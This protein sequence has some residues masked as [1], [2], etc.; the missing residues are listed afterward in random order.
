MK[1]LLLIYAIAVYAQNTTVSKTFES[2][3]E[4]KSGQSQCHQLSRSWYKL[5]ESLTTCINDY[6]QN[7]N[8]WKT[9]LNLTLAKLREEFSNIRWVLHGHIR[10]LKDAQDVLITNVFNTIMEQSIL[11]D[12]SDFN[13]VSADKTTADHNNS[14]SYNPET[15]WLTISTINSE[16]PVTTNPKVQ[17]CVRKAK[18]WV[19]KKAAEIINCSKNINNFLIKL[20][21]HVRLISKRNIEKLQQH[22]RN[23]V[24][25][26]KK[27]L[28]M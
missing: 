22:N 24:S 26:E 10:A 28:S 5:R 17:I 6:R 7:I 15:R 1:L 11:A 13:H 20:N 16:Q 27:E 14:N 9:D 18:K 8:D 21:M 3:K 19:K 4:H 12:S 23:K 2:S 25:T